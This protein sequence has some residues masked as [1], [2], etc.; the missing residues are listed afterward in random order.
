LSN[1]LVGK[2]SAHFKNTPCISC[3]IKCTPK[4]QQFEK[5]TEKQE[6]MSFPGNLLSASTVEN[7]ST[8]LKN[9]GNERGTNTFSFEKRN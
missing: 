4:L 9:I 8:I 6:Q 5:G 2:I 1:N 7:T 3:F